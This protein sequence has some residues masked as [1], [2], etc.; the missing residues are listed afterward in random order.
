MAYQEFSQIKYGR[1]GGYS[2]RGTRYLALLPNQAK[3]TLVHSTE[4]NATACLLSCSHEQKL[5]T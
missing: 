3:A 5:R 2:A 1:N 4:Q